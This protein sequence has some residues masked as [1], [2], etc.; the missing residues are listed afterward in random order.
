MALETFDVDDTLDNG[1]V[2]G[3]YTNVE[4]PTNYS[5]VSGGKYVS[6]HRATEPTCRA[7]LVTTNSIG[8]LFTYQVEFDTSGYY[9]D[10]FLNHC[11]VYLGA[12]RP[13][14]SFDPDGVGNSLIDIWFYY[15][16]YSCVTRTNSVGARQY[17]NFSTH[18]W[19]S[20][21]TYW[22][23]KKNNVYRIT[24]T[25]DATN[26]VVEIYDITGDTLIETITA[27]NAETKSIDDNAY[28]YFGVPAWESVNH[29][30]AGYWDNAGYEEAGE[31]ELIVTEGLTLGSSPSN[32][33]NMEIQGSDG[34]KLEALKLESMVA[35]L[36]RIDGMKS[37]S[38][39]SNLTEMLLS[40]L[41][42]LETEDTKS[43]MN[44]INVL[45]TDN[46]K[47]GDIRLNSLLANILITEGLKIGDNNLISTS[48][49]LL[50]EDTL[51]ISEL[52]TED[53]VATLTSV[54]S[55]KLSDTALTLLSIALLSIV[56][57]IEIED[58]KLVSSFSEFSMTD[59][60]EIEDSKILGLIAQIS[61]TD[62]ITLSD[63]A[64]LTTVFAILLSAT[65]GLK[66]SDSKSLSMV[67]DILKSE[68]IGLEDI[69][70]LLAT[71][72]INKSDGL[73]LSDIRTIIQLALVDIIRR[74]SPITLELS[75]SSLVTIAKSLNSA[76]TK[77]I[78]K[79]S[80]ID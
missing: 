4:Y 56:D 40:S 47:I 64:V 75:K 37:S 15:V 1:E 10:Q 26:T 29:Y 3:I 13:T 11:G 53:M 50:I 38:S 61:K 78:K 77:E 7:Y 39:I 46:L 16:D 25:R 31:F 68:S 71:I 45:R 35:S 34:I 30:P 70:N 55:I 69:K 51:A 32:L 2:Y 54:D 67:T 48:I 24:I 44:V 18:A 17:W 23:S 66:M 22:T 12:I 6:T 63:E 52:P 33:A 57:N 59:N 36:L 5:Y 76:I 19:Q 41:D 62:D 43:L 72:S 80:V 9:T 28:F 20:G 65:D 74:H 8:S 58:S 73:N 27:V 42:N 21:I 14:S 60:L 49:N 79:R